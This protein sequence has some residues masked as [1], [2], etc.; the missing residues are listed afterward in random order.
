MAVDAEGVA[1]GEVVEVDGLA[2][3]GEAGLGLFE[4]DLGAFLLVEDLSLAGAL[5][6]L[7]VAFGDDAAD[8]VGEGFGGG[9]GDEAEV[10]GFLGALVDVGGA[11]L[12]DAGAVGGVEV[13]GFPPVVFGGGAAFGASAG[14]ADGVFVEVVEEVEV[15]VGV[16]WEG[17]GSG[18]AYGGGGGGAGADVAE[19]A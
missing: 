8:F 17:G 10:E 19:V 15:A 12:H 13:A 7:L 6:A 3:G 5:A 14:G 1:R 11:F 18:A 4:L 16:A 9:F 2:P